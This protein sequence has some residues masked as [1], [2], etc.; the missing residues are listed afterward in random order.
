MTTIPKWTPWERSTGPKT[1]AGR[2]RVARNAY[3]GGAWL[4]YR[5]LS[6]IMNALLREQREAMQELTGAATV[7]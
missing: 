6:K 4:K 7:E 1:E 3:K 2:A 5:E